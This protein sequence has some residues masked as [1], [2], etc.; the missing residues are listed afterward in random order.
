MNYHPFK[1]DWLD[2]SLQETLLPGKPWHRV[3][4]KLGY[5]LA[6]EVEGQLKNPEQR[7][8]IFQLLG[9]PFVQKHFSSYL[10]Q[11]SLL[12]PPN[13]TGS[14]HDLLLQDTRVWLQGL[15]IKAAEQCGCQRRPAGD[16]SGLSSEMVNFIDDTNNLCFMKMQR[17]LARHETK[18]NVT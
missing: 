5:A 3:Y 17:L 12:H 16:Y 8:I 14:H 7:Q 1:V 9:I 13:L 18:K 6:H 2:A 10:D 15:M 4:E 11:P